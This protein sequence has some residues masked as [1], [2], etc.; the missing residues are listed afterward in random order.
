MMTYNYLRS[1]NNNHGIS[2]DIDHKKIE[3]AIRENIDRNM[4]QSVSCN[5][6][7]KK[8]L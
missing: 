5:T 8:S 4:I 6:E 2:F 7:R 3:E 1:I